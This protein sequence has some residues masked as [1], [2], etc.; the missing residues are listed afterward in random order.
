MALRLSTGLRNALLAAGGFKETLDGCKINFYTGTQPASADDAATGT[1]LVTISDNGG[2]GGLNWDT[3]PSGGSIPKAPAQ[4]WRG[5]AVAS[6]TAGWFRIYP[7]AGDP[8]VLSTTEARVDGA[9]ATSGAQLNAS[10][11]TVVSGATQDISSLSIT[12]PAS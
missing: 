6:G 1:L 11:V 7:S 12:L 10:S 4:T 3:A 8:S 9:I 5:T 2:V